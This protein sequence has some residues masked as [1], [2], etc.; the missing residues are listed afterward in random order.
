MSVATSPGAPVGFDDLEERVGQWL[1]DEQTVNERAFLG[2]PVPRT[3]AGKLPPALQPER[4][5]SWRQEVVWLEADAAR[6]YG[7]PAEELAA[8]LG[9]AAP[10]GHV[11]LMLHPRPP[12]AHRRLIRALGR[13]LLEDVWSTPTSSYRSV[14]AHTTGRQPVVLKLSLGAIIGRFRRAVDEVQVGTAV[15]ITRILDGIPQDARRLFGFDWFPEPAGVVDALSGEGWLL[16]SLPS[17]LLEPGGGRLIPAFS[18][19]AYSGDGEPMLVELIRRERRRAEELVVEEILEP[20]VR[21]LAYLLVVEGIHVEGHGQ[22]ILF[23]WGAD[24]RPTG[25]IVMRDLGDMSVSIPLRLARRRPLPALDDTLPARPPRPLGTVAS[26]HEGLSGQS[27]MIRAHEVIIAFGLNA[28]VWSINHSL[29]RFFPRYDGELVRR[30]Y[31]ELWRDAMMRLLPVRIS[32]RKRPL[33]IAT[34]EVIEHVLRRIDWPGLGSCGGAVLPDGAEALLIGG[35]ARRRRGPV[36][37]RLDCEW[38]ELYVDRGLPA[39]FRPSR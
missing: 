27:G 14:L 39:F 16:R 34:D 8:T 9:A 36:Y 10:P 24:E 22:N 11:A 21:A 30:R 1:E 3:S 17:V 20:Y 2:T 35:R 7:S 12:A 4:R 13:G 37:D 31:L 19:I 23:E 6:V 25:R 29:A 28:F 26:N 5:A 38:G 33:G 15:L 18:L 32:V